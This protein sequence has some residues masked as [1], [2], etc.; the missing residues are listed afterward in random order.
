MTSLE[1]KQIICNSCKGTD[2]K[3]SSNH[4]CPNS[5]WAKMRT[6]E[7][8]ETSVKLKESLKKFE[9]FIL[10]ENIT[11]DELAPAFCSNWME[12]E[13]YCGNTNEWKLD[14]ELQTILFDLHYDIASKVYVTSFVKDEN[15]DIVSE[16]TK[17]IYGIV[18]SNA[19]CRWYNR[20]YTKAHYG[21]TI[22]MN[23]W[24]VTVEAKNIV[25]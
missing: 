6:A 22:L 7:R 20:S 23:I 18:G 4:L 5:Y 13:R 9:N 2:H 16:R 1:V 11:M 12:I 25:F 14:Y 3:R 10:Q 15:L 24:G 21:T 17:I 19:G 8:L